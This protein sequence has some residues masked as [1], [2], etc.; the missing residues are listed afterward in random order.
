VGVGG[1]VGCKTGYA[2]AGSCGTVVPCGTSG[3]GVG[4]CA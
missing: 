2:G 3:V 4:T 1:A